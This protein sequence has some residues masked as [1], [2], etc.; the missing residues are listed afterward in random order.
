MTRTDFKRLRLAS[1]V[2]LEEI[3]KEVDPPRTRAA[4]HDMENRPDYQHW[5]WDD[6]RQEDIKLWDC[7][8][9]LAR[10]LRRRAP[11]LAEVE[12]A[13]AARERERAKAARRRAEFRAR[14][15]DDDTT[16][17]TETA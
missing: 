2:S 1:G 11:I 13:L 7:M 14:Q 9:A 3:A 17:T 5:L 12:A 8:R 4:I 10:I 6:D 16:T 15:D